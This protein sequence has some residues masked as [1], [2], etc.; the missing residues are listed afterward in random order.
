M[1]TFIIE[2]TDVLSVAL[3][4]LCNVLHQTEG[5]KTYKHFPKKLGLYFTDGLGSDGSL[6]KGLMPSPTTALTATISS[7]EK[8]CEIVAHR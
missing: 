2:L 5:I 6:V 1:F 3:H 8:C 4:H 7:E